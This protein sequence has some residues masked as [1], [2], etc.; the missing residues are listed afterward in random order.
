M[1]SERVSTRVMPVPGGRGPPRCI[2]MGNPPESSSGPWVCL[3]AGPVPSRESPGKAGGTWDGQTPCVSN[4][5]GI[6]ISFPPEAEGPCNHEGQASLPVVAAH[7]AGIRILGKVS[8]EV[9]GNLRRTG[10][11]A[12][13]VRGRAVEAVLR[14]AD[15][16]IINKPWGVAGDV[17]RTETS[18]EFRGDA[19]AVHGGDA[20]GVHPRECDGHVQ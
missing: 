14:S 5:R 15:M 20:C 18:Q 10:P 12:L 13:Q 8:N 19:T 9:P 6:L 17:P 4:S 2:L 16:E 1:A 11:Q 3:V 7:G